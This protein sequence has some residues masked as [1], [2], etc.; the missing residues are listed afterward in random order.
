MV[1]R[2]MI[3]SPSTTLRSMTIH[4]LGPFALLYISALICDTSQYGGS[5]QSM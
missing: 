4:G 1:L 5:A 2:M 3:Q